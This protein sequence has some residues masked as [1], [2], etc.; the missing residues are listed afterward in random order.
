MFIKNQ[1][2]KDEETLLEVLFD[3]DLG[4]PTAII[5]DKRTKIDSELDNSTD[6]QAYLA[7]FS[8]EEERLEIDTDE[9]QMRLSA[10]LM[11]QFSKFEVRN[12]KLFGTDNTGNTILLFEMDF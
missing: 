6:Y 2:F 4:T 3:F 11:E 9:R 7:T 10:F 5:A 1:V 12:R 8:D